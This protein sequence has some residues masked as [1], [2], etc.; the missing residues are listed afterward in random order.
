MF[1]ICSIS[2]QCKYHKGMNNSRPFTKLPPI[3]G[4]T[5]YTVKQYSGT[6]RC[7]CGEA[8]KYEK[9]NNIFGGID[10]TKNRYP[11]QV[12]LKIRIRNSDKEKECGGS[13]ISSQHILTAAHCTEGR[14]ASEISAYVGKHD[15]NDLRSHA[16][17]ISEITT[18]PDF[19]N[20]WVRTDYDFSILTLAIPIKDDVSP[21][22]LPENK[23]R[24]YRGEVATVTGWGRMDKAINNRTYPDVLQEVN[25]TVLSNGECREKHHGKISK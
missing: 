23:L 1:T 13:L 18:H 2:L 21:I 20:T 11:W 4:F 9:I 8:Q 16:A 22:C 19:M 10:S 17:S 15:K 12:S 7:N 14:S 25:I 6:I 5:P 24:S 3:E